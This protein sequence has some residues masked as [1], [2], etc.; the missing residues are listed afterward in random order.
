MT[1]V[2]KYIIILLVKGNDEESSSENAPQSE[3]GMVRAGG[4]YAMKIT[5]EP[6]G[7]KAFLSSMSCRLLRVS[8]SILLD[9]YR[10]LFSCPQAGGI[11]LFVIQVLRR[12]KSERDL[13]K[14][15]DEP[16]LR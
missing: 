1:L 14:S 8:E 2:K 6:Q 16:R 15:A 3:S 12:Y 5:S 9:M 10:W 11:F 7:S 4:G 13:Q